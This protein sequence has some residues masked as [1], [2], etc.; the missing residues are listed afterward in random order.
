MVCHFRTGSPI[1]DKLK[2]QEIAIGL[3]SNSKNE[4]WFHPCTDDRG[5][6]VEEFILSQNLCVRNEIGHPQHSPLP[7]ENRASI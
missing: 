2:G 1:I 5:V 7:L 6:A 3:D 4:V